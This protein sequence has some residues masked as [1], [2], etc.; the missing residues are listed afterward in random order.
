M[1]IL[2][3]GRGDGND[4]PLVHKALGRGLDSVGI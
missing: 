3:E 1:R 4:L 2:A